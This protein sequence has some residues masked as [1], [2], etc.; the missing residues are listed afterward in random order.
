MLPNHPYKIIR[1]PSMYHQRMPFFLIFITDFYAYRGHKDIV[2]DAP[3][4][5]ALPFA[6]RIIWPEKAA[7]LLH[8]EA[9]DF[10]NTAHSDHQDCEFLRYSKRG[11]L[12]FMVLIHFMRKPSNNCPN[13]G[14]KTIKPRQKA[15]AAGH[16]LNAAVIFFSAEILSI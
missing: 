7:V 2:P 13:I 14:K 12:L 5:N 4:R 9:Y 8:R 10:A 1:H 15:F 6:A 16:Y 11:D 3:D